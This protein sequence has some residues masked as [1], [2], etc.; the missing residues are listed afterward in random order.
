MVSLIRFCDEVQRRTFR[1]IRS[2]DGKFLLILPSPVEMK[3]MNK[4]VIYI[5]INVVTRALKNLECDSRRECI[6]ESL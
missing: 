1:P 4:R 5:A 2:G 6:T 3:K